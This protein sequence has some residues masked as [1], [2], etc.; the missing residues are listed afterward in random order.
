MTTTARRCAGCAGPLPEVEP[1]TLQVK[2]D[3]CG[4]VNEL[5]TAGRQPFTIQIETGRATVDKGARTL[6]LMFVLVAI[7]LTAGLGM[8]A[9]YLANRTVSQVTGSFGSFGTS[10][11]EVARAVTAI[12]PSDLGGSTSMGW[13][14]LT[15][16]EPPSGWR[17][18][19]PSRDLAWAT[20]I[21]H[22]WQPDARLTRI[23]LKRLPDTGV[24]DLSGAGEAEAGY[25][26]TS[27]AQI[28]RWLAAAA[29]GESSPTV[30]YEL[31]LTLTQGGV[32]ALATGGRPSAS[33]QPPS[34]AVNSL[35]LAAL[36]ERAK[37]GRG[38]VPASFYDGYMIFNERE[39]WVWYLTG[40]GQMQTLPRVRA[41][42]GA[43]YPYR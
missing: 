22:A 2:C 37:R 6:G 35:T 32:K 18:F 23:D 5:A 20:A 33:D 7:V 9:A 30:A 29:A 24:F 13:K 8:L 36:L 19:D 15:V 11:R 43:V 28:Q 21:A 1:G 3:F 40:R 14:S 38:F 42:D 34:A 27:P 39:G 31:M 25:R 16:G 4:V 17:A 26:F 41:K 10:V 12:A